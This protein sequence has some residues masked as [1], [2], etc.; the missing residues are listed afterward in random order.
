MQTEKET[1]ELRCS[2]IWGGNRTTEERFQLP[3]IDAY[4]SS[5]A[6][7]G[8]RGGDLH[9]L[10]TCGKGR[11][12][13]FLIADVAGHGAKVSNVATRFEQLIGKHIN[14]LDQSRLAK[15]LN[16]EFMTD[17]AGG[18]F[19]TALITSYDRPSD[20]FAVC[21]AGHPRPLYYSVRTR[22]WTLLDHTIE[23]TVDDI[24][25]LPLGIIVPT[26]YRQFAVRLSPGDVVVLYTDGFSEQRSCG[27]PIGEEGLLEIVNGLPLTTPETLVRSIRKALGMHESDY[28]RIDDETI[29]VVA[30]TE[31]PFAPLTLR[32]QFKVFGRMVPGPWHIGNA[33]PDISA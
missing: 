24:F 27:Q 31:R 6:F 18:R 8:G 1:L 15:T 4:L 23:T 25:N 5:A 17:N 22:Q 10:S 2:E 14:T 19:V 11:I 13:R 26:E 28:N 29:L 32:E 21:N 3:G 20:Y 9:Y 12:A 16:K 7:D 33:N 30:P